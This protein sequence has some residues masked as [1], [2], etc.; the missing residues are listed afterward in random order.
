MNLPHCPTRPACAP[1][2]VR[3]KKEGGGIFSKYIPIFAALIYN[4]NTHLEMN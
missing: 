2:V 3:I 4:K 1:L